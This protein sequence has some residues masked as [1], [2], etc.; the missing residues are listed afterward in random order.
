MYGR[1]KDPG[2][3]RHHVSTTQRTLNHVHK[4][5]VHESTLCASNAES[6]RHVEPKCVLEAVCWETLR[7]RCRGNTLHV[8][9]LSVLHYVCILRKYLTNTYIYTYI[10]QVREAGGKWPNW[11]P[12]TRICISPWEQMK[13]S[14]TSLFPKGLIHCSS[15]FSLK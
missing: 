6:T 14:S 5:T 1:F 7:S 12:V 3:A 11:L 8:Q 2:D 13:E 4:S 10:S 9:Q 15:W